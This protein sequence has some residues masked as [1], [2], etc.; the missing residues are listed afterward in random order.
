MQPWVW[1]SLPRKRIH[2][3]ID[4]DILFMQ[5][6]TWLLWIY[7]YI[8][9]T[10]CLQCQQT[11]ARTVSIS[12]QLISNNG[13][14]I[15]V[16][17][18]EKKN[19]LSPCHTRWVYLFVE[20]GDLATSRSKTSQFSLDVQSDTTCRCYIHWNHSWAPVSNQAALKES[21][22]QSIFLIL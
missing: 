4:F 15:C 14:T 3:I 18:S 17:C 11:T 19:K 16:R 9:M 8:Y 20:V 22:Y 1:P 12:E 7:I 21:S 6:L 10:K 2:N 5:A 13:P